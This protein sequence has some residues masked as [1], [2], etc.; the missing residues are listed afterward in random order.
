MENEK[1][2]IIV[3]E[4]LKSKGENIDFWKYFYMEI[5]HNA[6]NSNYN[7]ISIL[8]SNL[9]F[10]ENVDLTLDIIDFIFDYG[11]EDI[12]SHIT[13][14]FLNNITNLMT[15]NYKTEKNI[16]EKILFLIKKWG[17][18]CQNKEIFSNF[19]NIYEKLKE[20]KIEFPS[21]EFFLDTYLKY[22]TLDDINEAKKEYDKFKNFNK[23]FN[24]N[25]TTF[26][27]TL[28]QTFNTTNHGDIIDSEPEVTKK[29]IFQ[30]I[31]L[32]A[33]NNQSNIET[34]VDIKGEDNN[35]LKAEKPKEIRE[36]GL[37]I[38]KNIDNNRST[39]VDNNALKLKKEEEAYDIK[40][41]KVKQNIFCSPYDVKPCIKDNKNNYHKYFTK[42]KEKLILFKKGEQNDIKQ[43]NNN[44]NNNNNN[45]N[46]QKGIYN[47]QNHNINKNSINEIN[48]N[49]NTKFNNNNSNQITNNNDRTNNF[50]NNQSNEF[51]QNAYNNIGSN[52]R[53]NSFSKND[54]TFNKINEIKNINLSVHNK[55]ISRDKY[56]PRINENYNTNSINI[57]KNK[58]NYNNYITN[59]NHIK[60]GNYFGDFNNPNNNSYKGGENYLRYFNYSNNY[61]IEQFKSE[62]GIKI[63]EINKW[64]DKG[65]YS[66]YNTYSGLLIKGLYELKKY[67]EKCNELFNMNQNNKYCCDILSKLK[68]DIAQTCERY[69]NLNNKKAV[70]PFK[71]AFLNI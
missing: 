4:I 12:I 1:R 54:N 15:S 43:N 55:C 47:Y 69:N 20:K 2:V 56:N 53:N 13:S 16:L 26:R 37:I 49:Q 46:S 59:N 42:S 17:T 14:D 9:I 21:I 23:I 48:N 28:N 7:I 50:I 11:S 3:N 62:L 5:N 6:K 39:I 32:N 19:R 44:L 25:K 35:T 51:N 70:Y 29:A 18:E 58:L 68:M 38:L 40:N 63:Y 8:N 10:N 45:K 67:S 60:K 41:E 30:N 57:C 27:Q 64:I 34:K 24:S 66:F 65:Y 33:N 36:D 71:S 52:N 61:S 31:Y 22:I